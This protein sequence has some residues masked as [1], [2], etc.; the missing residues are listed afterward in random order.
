ML[1]RDHAHRAPASRSSVNICT[2][3]PVQLSVFALSYAPCGMTREL[4]SLV[5]AHGSVLVVKLVVKIV[6]KLVVK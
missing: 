1:K 2:F 3:L 4:E 6:V 5:L